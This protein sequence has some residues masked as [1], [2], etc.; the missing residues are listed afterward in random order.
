MCTNC[1]TTN[2]CAPTNKIAIQTSGSTI[3]IIIMLK[4]MK[5]TTFIGDMC[6]KC[7]LF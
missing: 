5:Y 4:Q 3:N 7:G 6:P 1:I 2:L